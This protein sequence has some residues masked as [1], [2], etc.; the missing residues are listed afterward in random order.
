M[1]VPAKRDCRPHVRDSCHAL[2]DFKGR[3]QFKNI[4]MSNIGDDITTDDIL[5]RYYLPSS[6]LF[7]LLC[8]LIQVV[9]D[10]TFHFHMK[11]LFLADGF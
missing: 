7:S 11:S 3:R 6:I 10:F 4:A 5:V 9:V 2:Q 1:A 8:F